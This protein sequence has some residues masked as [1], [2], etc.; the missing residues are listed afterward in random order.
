MKIGLVLFER[1]QR[2]NELTNQPTN[3]QT[4]GLGHVRYQTRSVPNHFGT[5]R[6]CSVPLDYFGT[7]PFRYHAISSSVPVPFRYRVQFGTMSVS[8][9]NLVKIAQ[10]QATPV[11]SSKTTANLVPKWSRWY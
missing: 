4:Q 1:S 3:K 7:C 8:V 10:L 9:P 6:T 5:K 11:V 2:T